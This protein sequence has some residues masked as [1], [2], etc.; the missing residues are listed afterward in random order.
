MEKLRIPE[1]NWTARN[2]L[3]LKANWIRIRKN[4]LMHDKLLNYA[5]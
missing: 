5:H 1:H 3:N 2:K 4:K